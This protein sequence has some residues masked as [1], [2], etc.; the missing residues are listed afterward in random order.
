MNASVPSIEPAV[1]DEALD[2]AVGVEQA[3]GSL[4]RLL[5]DGAD[6]GST[7]RAKFAIWPDIG[8]L[9]RVRVHQVTGDEPGPDDPNEAPMLDELEVD[10]GGVA[11]VAGQEGHR[12]VFE[13]EFDGEAIRPR[14]RCAGHE[15]DVEVVD[16]P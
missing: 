12:V 10:L 4:A 15:L 5:A 7:G 9:V 11:Q 2:G 3:D 6:P 16:G 14:V 1:E 8:R 13:L